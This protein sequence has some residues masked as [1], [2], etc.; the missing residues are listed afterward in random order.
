MKS[1]FLNKSDGPFKYIESHEFLPIR[2]I[3]IIYTTRIQ[4]VFI[5]NTKVKII[6]E[7]LNM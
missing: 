6:L 5:P 1:I 3:V 7:N 2:E 4:Y